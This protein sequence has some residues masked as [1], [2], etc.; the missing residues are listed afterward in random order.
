M[1]ADASPG[2]PIDF[3]DIENDDINSKSSIEINLIKQGNA[4]LISNFERKNKVP[5]TNLTCSE[6]I[7]YDI[8]EE[9][10]D[11]NNFKKC[12]EF[13]NGNNIF[14]NKNNRKNHDELK[15]KVIADEDIDNVNL[16]RNEQI[17]INDRNL[18]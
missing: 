10:I 9:N 13:M 5:K 7:N 1:N 14:K 4:K 8:I 12:K 11:E 3:E 15:Y 6:E 18:I 16:G 2:N 17:L